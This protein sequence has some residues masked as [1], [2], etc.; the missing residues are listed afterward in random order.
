VQTMKLRTLQ[1]PTRVEVMLKS[2]VTS[3]NWVSS[4]DQ[5]IHEPS[6]LPA[7]LQK[8]ARKSAKGDGSS[9]AWLRRDGVRLFVGEMSLELSKE[10]GCPVLQVRQHSE[11]GALQ[12][13]SIW[14]QLTEGTWKRCEH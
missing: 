9:L 10:R 14:V 8:L 13:Y 3:N 7:A 1:K 12:D 4:R 6:D 2:L 11:D 5:L